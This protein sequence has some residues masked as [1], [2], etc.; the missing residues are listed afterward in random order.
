[1]RPSCLLPLEMEKKLTSVAWASYQ[2]GCDA[3]PR[4][5]PEST[6]TQEKKAA[7]TGADNY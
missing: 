1:M 5:G 6:H 7:G 2:T 3:F 4:S